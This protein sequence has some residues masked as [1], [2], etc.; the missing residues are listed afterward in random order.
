MRAL[1]ARLRASRDAPVLA[2]LLGVKA[3]VLLQGALAYMTPW[4]ERF[5]GVAGYLAIW[6]RWDVL[7]YL[8]VA[9]HGYHATGEQAP[10]LTF[11]P[12]FPA[13]VRL[14]EPLCGSFLA[15]GFWVAN[16]ASIAVAL[17]FLRLAALDGDALAERAVFFLF[18]FPTSYLLHVPYTESLF[19]AAAVGSFLAARQDR[20]ALAGLL[21][22]C[23]SLTRINGIAL[24]AALAVEVLL[25]WRAERRFRAAW[26]FVLLVPAAAGGY[27]LLNLA[28]T[29]DAFAF[30]RIQREH[31]HRLPAWPWL[32]Y[33]QMWFDAF[34]IGSPEQVVLRAQELL[35]ATIMAAATVAS[36]FLLRPSYAVF[37]AANAALALGFRHPWA[38]PRYT[39]V[40]FPLFLLMARASRRPWVFAL[41]CT[42]SL[43]NLALSIGLFVRGFWPI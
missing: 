25:R 43:L 38:V 23:A 20:W 3:L 9:E 19:L 11:Y 33:V 14:A 5:E 7:N 36:C 39:L 41:F 35:F 28:V 13:L 12:L 4:N 2:G 1:W 42:W 37:M 40:M 31:F 30:L 34:A 22:A 15:A 16:L 32:G 10:L 6:N 27:L 17:L 18:V 26:L 29:G 8:A 24:G 21:G